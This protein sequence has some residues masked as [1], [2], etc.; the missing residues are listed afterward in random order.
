M[1]S[2]LVHI[3]YTIVIFAV[4]IPFV[5]YWCHRRRRNMRYQGHVI[6]PGKI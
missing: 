3:I 4:L 2:G 5:C 1:K 6:Q